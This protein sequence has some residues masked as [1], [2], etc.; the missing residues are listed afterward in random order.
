[1]L[2]LIAEDVLNNATGTAAAEKGEKVLFF[3]FF[4]FTLAKIQYHKKDA[5]NCTS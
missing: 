4:C 1:M 5:T 3:Y 2:N